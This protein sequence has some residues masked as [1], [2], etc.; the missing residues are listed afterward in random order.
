MF[1]LRLARG[2]RVPDL[3]RWLLTVL[4]AA[5]VSAFL[6]RSLGRAMSDPLGGEDALVRLFWCLPPLAAVAWFA[7]VTARAVPAQRPERIT[8]LRAA[9]RLRPDP[10]PDRR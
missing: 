4:A 7:A 10:H 6:L 9:G 5:V 2:Y 3:G 1:Y 8:G